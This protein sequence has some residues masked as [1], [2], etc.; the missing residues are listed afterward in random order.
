MGHRACLRKLI[1]ALISFAVVDRSGRIVLSVKRKFLDVPHCVAA[2]AE[3]PVS[4]ATLKP[5]WHLS[6]ETAEHETEGSVM[7][8]GTLAVKFLVA[9]WTPVLSTVQAERDRDS[10]AMSTR[11]FPVLKLLER[12]CVPGVVPFQSQDRPIPEEVW[13]TALSLHLARPGCGTEQL[14]TGGLLADLGQARLAHDDG[15]N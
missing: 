9:L 5:C 3:R 13:N 10:T 4:E 11:H 8:P 2:V 1:I 14:L 12:K 7:P 15:T 6:T